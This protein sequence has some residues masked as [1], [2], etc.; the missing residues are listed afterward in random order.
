MGLQKRHSSCEFESGRYCQ[1]P[2]CY[3]MPSVMPAHAASLFVLFCFFCFC[4]I[5][6]LSGEPSFCAQR[7]NNLPPPPNGCIWIVSSSFKTPETTLF[8]LREIEDCVGACP[9]YSRHG[10][11]IWGSSIVSDSSWP[12]ADRGDKDCQGASGSSSP[13]ICMVRSRQAAGVK[14]FPTLWATI[15]H[16]SVS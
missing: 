6:K 16:F 15:R 11:C 10:R 12:D 7:K 2:E 8:G 4:L 9:L 13:I 1:G 14:P 5:L 3:Q